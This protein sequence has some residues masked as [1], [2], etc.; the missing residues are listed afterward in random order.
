MKFDLQKLSPAEKLLWNN[1]VLDKSHIDLDA[2]AY[3]Y[4]AEIRYR[5]LDGCEARL[6]TYGERAIISISSSSTDGRK[7][8]SLAHELAHWICDKRAGSFLCAKEDIG[9]QNSEA[10][11]IESNANDFASQLILPDYLV[12]PWMEGKK[13][14]L[15][16]ASILAT[17]FSSSCY[18]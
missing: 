10:K 13:I 3:R 11:T 2:L 17:D 7:R 16:V 15:D 1:G 6:V 18:Y 14:T 5:P 9:P 12:T 4:N 8:F